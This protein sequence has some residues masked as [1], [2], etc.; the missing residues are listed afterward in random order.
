LFFAVPVVAFMARGQDLTALPYG[1]GLVLPLLPIVIGV[2]FLRLSMK[3]GR[4]SA[5]AGVDLR[6]ER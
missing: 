4:A 5:E 3:L 1:L 6:T 2:Y